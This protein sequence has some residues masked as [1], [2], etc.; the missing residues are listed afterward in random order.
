M[1]HTIQNEYLSIAVNEIGAEL[2]S[3]RTAADGFEYLWQPDPRVW[4]RQS[5]LL[6]PIVGRVENDRYRV[7]DREYPMENHGFAKE[8]RF[9]LLES[10]SGRL[11]FQLTS[12]EA[13]LQKYPYH[14]QLQVRYTLDGP[15]LE[16]GYC[17]ANRDQ[18]RMWFSIGAHPGFRCPLEAG[19]TMNDYRLEFERPER[20]ER[21]LAQ[22]NLLTGATAPFLNGGQVVPLSYELFQKGAVILKGLRSG[23][24]TLKSDRN[25]RSITVSYPGFPFLGIW[26]PPGPFVCIEPW[27]GVPGTR[28]AGDDFTKKEGILSLDAGEVFE[29]A[30]RI[31]VE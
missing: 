3:L 12:D 8:T 5:P 22:D 18:R 4:R 27:Y 7:D 28:G 30:Y 24:I 16:T 17:V 29:C 31:R 10:G 19:E 15:E 11:V 26:S 23:R 1:E 21:H 25:P 9:E 20:I 2:S 6:F 13:T 14:F